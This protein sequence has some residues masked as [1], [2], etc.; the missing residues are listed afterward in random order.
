[1]ALA[2]D[3]LVV[4]L[5]ERIVLAMRPED[6]RRVVERAIGQELGILTRADVLAVMDRVKAKLPTVR[7][8]ASRAAREALLCVGSIW[9][10]LPRQQA[11]RDRD[12]LIP[13]PILGLVERACKG[14]H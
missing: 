14:E 13:R 11:V 8:E 2:R 7:I 12:H 3:E 10:H 6:A 4:V 1:M 5:R 9:P